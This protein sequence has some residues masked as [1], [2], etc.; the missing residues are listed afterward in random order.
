MNQIITMAFKDLRLLFRDKLGA[1]F[2]IGFPILMGLFFGTI[3]GG[4]SSGG[5][6]KMKVA[7]VDQ[8]KTEISRK[9]IG[10]LKSNDSIELDEQA[11]DPARELVR[12]GKRVAMVVLDK[13]F[14]KS[15]GVFWEEAPTIRV[16][17]DP[18]RSAESAMLQG[19]IME[20]IGQLAG[21]RLQDA[22]AMQ[23]MIDQ[24][25]Q[26][27]AEDDTISSA[28]KLLVTGLLGSVEQMVESIDAIQTESDDPAATA[29]GGGGFQFAN[30]ESIDVSRK[31]D[32][33]SVNGQLMKRKSN[34][35]ISFPQA[36]LWGVLA[37]VAG[38][39]ISIAKERTQ[40]TMTRLQVAPVSRTGVL[41]GKALACFL[42][43]ILVI[44]LMTTL[45]LVLGMTPGSYPMLILASVCVAICFVGIMMIMSNLGNTE[46]S[47]NGSGWAINMVMAMF[48]GCMIPVMFMPGFMQNLSHFSPVK[49]S[50]LAMEGAIWR[51][52]SLAEMM[53]PCGILLGVGVVGMVIGSVMLSRK[54]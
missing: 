36:M 46:Q 45:G 38:F 23:E 26:Q 35:D 32:P 17:V 34:W 14:G 39:A 24:S 43:V 54:S 10:S 50:I 42:A 20:S 37:C 30:I 19:M 47:V 53:L 40:G 44:I 12:K 28:N 13:E 48:G 15:A 6:A 33:D 9:F 49:W 27:L 22:S 52:F 2:I 1:F 5:S 18:S 25:R 21:T 29:N 4:P 8:D 51:E 31:I 11:L 7:I 16:G 41:A 3:M